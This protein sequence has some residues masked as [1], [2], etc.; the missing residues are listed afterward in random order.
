MISFIKSFFFNCLFF[1]IIL[2]FKKI[3]LLFK[4]NLT[5]ENEKKKIFFKIKINEKKS[6]YIN[7]FLNNLEKTKIIFEINFSLKN[8]KKEK[9]KNFRK[10][11]FF[12]N[13]FNFKNFLVVLN[14]FKKK[15]V[16]FLY[17]FKN[18]N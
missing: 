17:F 11:I 9:K 7:Q 1:V 12:F 18:K 16:F 8:G 5:F 3:N 2:L 14:L 13:I 6:L 4:K 10:Y 15:E